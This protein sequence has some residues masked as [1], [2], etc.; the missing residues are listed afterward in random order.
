MGTLTWPLFF[1]CLLLGAALLAQWVLQRGRR[2]ILAALGFLLAAAAILVADH[3]IVTQTKRVQA[4][5]YDLA[6]AVEADDV[7][8]CLSFFSEGDKTDR[9]LVQQ[10]VGMVRIVGAIHISDMTINMSSAESRAVSTF[11]AT[12]DVTYQNQTNRFPTRWELT[13]QREGNEWKVIRVRRLQLM[14][15]Q[16]TNPPSAVD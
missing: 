15:D 10:A 11:R 9:Q 4:N 3:F 5:I 8:R 2:Q 6:K 16:E 13:W 7:E 12:A 1:L 14:G